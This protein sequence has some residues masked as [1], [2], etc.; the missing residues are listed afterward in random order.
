M[1]RHFFYVS[2][3]TVCV[4][5]GAIGTKTYGQAIRLGPPEVNVSASQEKARTEQAKAMTTPIGRGF[6]KAPP[7][8]PMT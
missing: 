4:A 2:L 3:V 7:R 6:R 8:G 5:L 1:I